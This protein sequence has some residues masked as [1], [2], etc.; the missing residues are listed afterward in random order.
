MQDV[1]DV[2]LGPIG[3]SLLG[4]ALGD[5]LGAGVEGA[6]AERI[7]Q[8]RASSGGAL[9][10]R[11][12]PM[13]WTDDTQQALTLLEATL[14][15]GYP[16]PRWVGERWVAM[17]DPWV[18]RGTGRGFRASVEAFAGSGDPSTS[19][20]TD[21]AGN[22]AA[23]RI[24]PTAVALRELSDRDFVDRLVDVSLITHRE[25][26]ALAGMLAV[27][28][29]ARAV[30]RA[31]RYSVQDGRAILGE[32][33]GWLREEE[34]RLASHPVGIDGSDRRHEI[35]D[36][37][38]GVLERWDDWPE[39]EAWIAGR[40]SRAVGRPTRIGEGF[41]GA[42]VVTAVSWSLWSRSE[43]GPTVEAAVGFGDDAD[44]LAAMVGGIAGAGTPSISPGGWGTV[45]AWDGL[46]SWALGADGGARAEDLPDLLELERRLTRLLGA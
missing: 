21:R 35:S 27:A 19:G 23:M 32:L 46:A 42:S 36:T 39:I 15:F 7:A 28:F 3:G 33:V 18:H 20:R 45:A 34:D 2:D 40:A 43:L 5:C 22:G 17:T 37:L 8:I 13:A 12:D 30:G 26:R 38:E 24:A 1:S 6:S 41:V 29:C 16:D 4:L 44:T 11:Y 25:I 14:R 9:R 31:G 10:F